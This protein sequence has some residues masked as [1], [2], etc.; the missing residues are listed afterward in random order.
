MKKWKTNMFLI[1]FKMSYNFKMI[2]I[3]ILDQFD[4]RVSRDT[5]V[6]EAKRIQWIQTGPSK[7]YRGTWR[8]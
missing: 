4:L 8:D 7:L 1:G 5:S 3:Q 2:M 6:A